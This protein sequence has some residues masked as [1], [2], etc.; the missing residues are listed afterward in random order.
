[1]TSVALAYSP[2]NHRSAGGPLAPTLDPLRTFSAGPQRNALTC[3]KRY[4]TRHSIPKTN[5]SV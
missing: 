2:Q 4:A 3:F 1:M 5:C